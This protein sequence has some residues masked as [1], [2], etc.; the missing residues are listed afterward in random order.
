M[1]IVEQATLQ[2]YESVRRA[3]ITP[4]VIK[5]VRQQQA[6]QRQI[7]LLGGPG[8]IHALQRYKDIIDRHVIPPR[9]GVSGPRAKA[10]AVLDVSAASTEGDG[11]SVGGGEGG[12][13][14]DDD[15]GGDSDSDGPRR[16]TPAISAKHSAAPSRRS[17][18]A[19]RRKLKSPHPPAVIMHTHALAALICIL[20]IC[21]VGAVAFAALGHERLALTCL[22]LAAIDKWE[23]ARALVNPK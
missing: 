1:G 23:L 16:H 14:G 22:G 10:S 4:D 2:A 12:A 21:I 11:A 13:G 19:I 6:V 15:D 18:R 7:E 3:G 17:S 8:V 9:V 5:Q 20:V